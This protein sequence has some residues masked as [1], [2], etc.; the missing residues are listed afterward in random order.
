V[1]FVAGFLGTNVLGS[2][3]L[4]PV[5]SGGPCARQIQQFAFSQLL[6]YQF[7]HVLNDGVFFHFTKIG[8]R[9]Y[10]H[11][12]TYYHIPAASLQSKLVEARRGSPIMVCGRGV[13][14][15]K[16]AAPTGSGPNVTFLACVRE[17]SFKG[18]RGG[19]LT[20]LAISSIMYWM[21]SL[22]NS[23]S[24]ASSKRHVFVSHK[25]AV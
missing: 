2:G 12:S 14:G 19:A 4:A 10:S 5:G 8:F 23:S 24:P 9:G 6:L 25:N 18:D 16:G 15:I 17:W 3:D 13:M 22:F 21:T 7:I 20:R 1:R 11:V